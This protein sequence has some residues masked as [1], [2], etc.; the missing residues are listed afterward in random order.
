MNLKPETYMPV[1]RWK[2]AEKTALQKLGSDVRA[3]IVPL[4]ELVPKDFFA[5]AKQGM[6]ARVAKELI[7][8]SG[9][10]H[11]F[12][13]DP[14][15]LGNE[16]AAKCIATICREVTRVNQGIGIATGVGRSPA[17][18]AQ[19]SHVLQNG[20]ADLVLR[21][22]SIE[23]RQAGISSAI[24]ETLAAL[25]RTREQTHLV[26]EF[27]HIPVSGLNYLPWLRNLPSLTDWRSVTVIAGTFPK[28]LSQLAANEERTLERGEWGSWCELQTMGATAVNFGDYTIQHAYFEDNEGK[29]FNFSASI[30]YTT[31][32]GYLV[33]RGEGVRNDGSPG[34]QQYLSEATLL[35]E[36][37][38]FSGYSFSWGDAYI[39]EKVRDMTKTGGP[40]EW[41]SAGIN[42]HI[43]LIV[44][45]IRERVGVPAT[46]ILRSGNN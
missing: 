26:L 27:G 15:L 8:S 38:E 3:S 43:T 39:A 14:A 12:I 36:R 17:Y 34:Y 1:L 24:N 37:P 46:A 44:N 7:K 19:V 20:R 25:A 30:R 13:I 5:D 45:Q 22:E 10:Q 29:G 11:P 33:L 18:Q 23:F 32:D 6:L 40:K 21:V 9:W 28:D 41:L 42:H 2:G 16:I 4:V 31:P 35:M